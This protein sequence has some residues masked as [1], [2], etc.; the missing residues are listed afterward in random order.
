MFSFTVNLEG[1]APTHSASPGIHS[2]LLRRLG[3]SEHPSPES[4][5]LILLMKL[6]ARLLNLT[7][8]SLSREH[9]SG[10]A[11]GATPIYGGNAGQRLSL[12]ALDSTNDTP[13]C[14]ASSWG[15]ATGAPFLPGC[16][17]HSP[18]P[19]LSWHNSQAQVSARARGRPPSLTLEHP[20]GP[21]G[22]A[23]KG[24]PT[25]RY[26]QWLPSPGALLQFPG[27]HVA[28]PRAGGDAHLARKQK[29]DSSEWT[30]GMALQSPLPVVAKS[31][32]LTRLT[33]P[34]E[35]LS[36]LSH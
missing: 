12:L 22:G 14:P 26:P 24:L 5:A 13:G 15:W 36:A 32:I 20:K 30:H 18:F 27:R 9:M 3:V 28:P 33:L 10:E 23:P 6:G 34:Q 8:G 4:A 7:V 25:Q 11:N 17:Q 29:R 19:I 31:D 21:A 35:I 16:L 2:A 1:A